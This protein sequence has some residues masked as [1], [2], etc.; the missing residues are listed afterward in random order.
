[1]KQNMNM[2]P[3]GAEKIRFKTSHSFEIEKLLETGLSRE[4]T[5][6]EPPRTPARA[7]IINIIR[8]K[9]SAFMKLCSSFLTYHNADSSPLVGLLKYDIIT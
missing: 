3:L 2:K 5:Y 8:K 6:K 9:S 7:L 1:M 4:V